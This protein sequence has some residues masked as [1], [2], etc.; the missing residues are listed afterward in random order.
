MADDFKRPFVRAEDY[1]ELLRRFGGGFAGVPPKG[2]LVCRA[3]EELREL[4]ARV[5]FLEAR[6]ELVGDAGLERAG[7]MVRAGED[8]ERAFVR[9]KSVCGV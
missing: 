1:I 4:E 2:V 3:L 7:V 8:L 9:F 5:E 6:F